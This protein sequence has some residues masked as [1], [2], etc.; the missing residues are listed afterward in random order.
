VSREPALET[1]L[2]TMEPVLNPGI[3]VFA[4]ATGDLPVDQAAVIASIREPEGL[5]LI[6]EESAASA[7]GLSGVYRCAWITLAVHSDLSAVGLTA[8]ISSALRDAGISANVVVG[9]HHDH[10]FVPVHEAALAMAALQRLQQYA[11]LTPAPPT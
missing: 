6:L 8:A 9:L 4:K 7:A 5:S 11:A 1:L 10:L 2:R 3:Y